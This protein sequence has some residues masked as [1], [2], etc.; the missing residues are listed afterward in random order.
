MNGLLLLFCLSLNP[1]GEEHV[2]IVREGYLPDISDFAEI[3]LVFE[4]H[5]WFEQWS[6]TS[7][8]VDEGH[9]VSF[10]G[11]IDD[12]GAVDAFH[13]EKKYALEFGLKAMQLASYYQ[14][15]E[16]K[17]KLRFTIRFLITK[18]RRFHTHSGSLGILSKTG[19]WRE[20]ELVN[21][22]L[23]SVIEGMYTNQNPYISLVLGLPF[24]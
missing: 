19:Q 9:L 2:Q 11:T 23:L 4:A 7:E 21:K 17:L 8:E 3:G 5:K 13:A 18:G 15:D 10:S 22:T 12:Q 20:L 1:A 6:W 16:D 14:L 24:K